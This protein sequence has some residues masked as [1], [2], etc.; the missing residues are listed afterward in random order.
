MRIPRH[1]G[2]IP[3]GNRRW[4]IE[5][6]MTKEMGYNKGLD[7]GLKLFKLCEK[8]GIEEITYYGFT[9]DNTKRPKVQRLAFTEACIEAVKMLAKENASLLVVGNTSSPMFPKELIP[10]TLRR[11]DFGNGGLKV[12][13]LVN[14]GWEWD[15]KNYFFE[16]YNVENPL[17]LIYSR[18]ISRVDLIIRWGGRRRL[19]G[20]LPLQSVYSDFYVIDDYWPDFKPEHFYNALDW[21]DKQDVTLGG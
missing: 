11:R 17:D 15:L 2:V 7:P 19:S 10:Y 5:N 14:Y 12:N 9:V 13:F 6:G 4:A 16:K 1:I 18:D 21:Y 8:E 20:F 3:D